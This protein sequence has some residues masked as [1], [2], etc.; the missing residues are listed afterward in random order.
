[1]K[2]TR[3]TNELPLILGANEIGML[4]RWID[5][6]YGCIRIL[7]V[8]QETAFVWE[9]VSQSQLLKKHKLNTRS[10]T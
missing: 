2:Y 10:S 7:E 3:G 9:E 5:G 8:T 4:K 6:S 1:M